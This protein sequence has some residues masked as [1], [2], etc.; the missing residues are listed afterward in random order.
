MAEQPIQVEC[1]NCDASLILIPSTVF[2]DDEVASGRLDLSTATDPTKNDE[3]VAHFVLLYRDGHYMCRACG[4]EHGGS[5]TTWSCGVARRTR[6]P[7]LPDLFFEVDRDA[8]PLLDDVGIGRKAQP[9]ATPVE[10]PKENPR[11]TRS[12]EKFEQACELIKGA[13]ESGEW[14]SSNSIHKKFNGKI[15]EGMYGRVKSALKIEHRR[16]KGDSG[17]ATY[18]WRL[19]K[20]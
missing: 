5:G 10:T 6:S 4:A 2:G 15:A 9:T 18:E 13:L 20:A 1:S 3:V 11:T 12:R 8:F 7:R 19:P 14:V 17:P 16:V